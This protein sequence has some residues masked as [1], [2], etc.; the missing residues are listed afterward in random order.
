MTR[1]RK[2]TKLAGRR[3]MVMRDTHGDVE[4]I[5]PEFI[6]RC[7]TITSIPVKGIVDEQDMSIQLAMEDNS[8]E[9]MVS[10]DEI[11]FIE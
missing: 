2:F 6:G 11:E 1:K 3:V 7:A 5:S 4:G 8:E 9:L 10:L